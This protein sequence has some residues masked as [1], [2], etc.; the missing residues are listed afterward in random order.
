M[1]RFADA[2]RVVEVVC[3]QYVGGHWEDYS[4]EAFAEQM[5]KYDPALEVYEVDDIVDIIRYAK[6]WA[7]KQVLWKYRGVLIGDR[8]IEYTIMEREGE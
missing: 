4:G 8:D 7:S 1:V 6:A 5:V 2:H 3:N